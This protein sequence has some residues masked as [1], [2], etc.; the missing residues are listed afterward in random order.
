LQNLLEKRTGKEM[1][2]RIDL[3][4]GWP[5]LRSVSLS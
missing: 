2:C 5:V 4:H 1:K 3:C